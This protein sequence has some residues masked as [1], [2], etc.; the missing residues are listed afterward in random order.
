VVVTTVDDYNRGG[1]IGG[2]K[3][4]LQR[5]R[6]SREGMRVCVCVNARTRLCGTRA[7]RDEP[8]PS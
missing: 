2:G 7:A 5:Q 8:R 1:S 4:F 6:K 3:Y